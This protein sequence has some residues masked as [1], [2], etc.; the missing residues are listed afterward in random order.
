MLN[1]DDRGEDDQF[2]QNLDDLTGLERISV[3]SF[4]NLGN[5]RAFFINAS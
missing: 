5:Y 3:D 2:S 4:G 1:Y